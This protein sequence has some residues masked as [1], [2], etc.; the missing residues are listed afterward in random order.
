MKMI[1]IPAGRFEM[2]ENWI[3]DWVAYHTQ[4]E[5]AV[6]A[7]IRPDE[8]SGGELDET[9]RHDVNISQ[10]F[11]IASYEVTNLQYEKFDPAHR[12][13]RT[14]RNPGDNDAV[15]NISWLDATA[16]CKW[17]SD[18]E[19]LPYRLPTEAEWEYA[20]R[21][22]TNSL[23]NTGDSLPA[24]IFE[25][26][27]RSVGQAPPNAWGL[28]DMHG[29]VEEWCNDWYGPYPGN[30]QTDP[31]GPATGRVKIL[32][33]GYSSELDVDWPYLHLS[34]P[35][36]RSA[37]RAGNIPSF[38]HEYYGFRL[39]MA[40]PPGGKSL[41]SETPLWAKDV[42]Q[43]PYDWSN[44]PDPEEPFFAEI[45]EFAHPP[46]NKDKIP[47]YAINHVPAITWCENGDMLTIWWTTVRD[48]G[49]TSAILGSRLRTGAKRYDPPS[50]FLTVPDRCL[51]GS[52]LF[53][54]GQGRIIWLQNIAPGGAWNTAPL[55]VSFST[56]NGVNWTDPSIVLPGV[57]SGQ[58]AH[59]VMTRDKKGVLWQTADHYHTDEVLTGNCGATALYRS[60]DRGLNWKKVT[61]LDWQI[62]NL[63]KEGKTG[64][65]IAG[66]HGVS[67]MLQDGSLLGFGRRASIDGNLIKSLSKDGGQSW[68]YSRSDFPSIRGGQRPS[69]LRLQEGPIL[70]VSYTGLH[71]IPGHGKLASFEEP[72]TLAKSMGGMIFTDAEG[73]EYTG[74]GLYAAISYDE[75]QTWETRKLITPGGAPQIMFGGGHHHHFLMDN[76]HAE[77]GGYSY[78]T[79]TPDG[80]IHL[81][82]SN[83]HYRLNLK[84]LE[85][86]PDF[87]K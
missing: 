54:D 11:F 87:S 62:E 43:S 63:G 42:S 12:V 71:T 29:G 84:W 2:G 31:I 52:S 79:Q 67:I 59:M 56:D 41:P 23:F 51:H 44:G 7:R 19:G 85:T 75:G 46:A 1:P 32:R 72:L 66:P 25:R 53:H 16:F 50:V 5:L 17:L 22:G 83:L 30:P 9:P 24:D 60:D 69:M 73:V 28:F 37:N 81:I 18:E 68:T 4:M 40:K 33:G 82:T 35:Y 64:G 86:A 26:S 61:R 78:I 49:R 36:L 3:G 20:C 38:S 77:T 76:T 47:F 27:T 70:F 21:A 57:R 65:A 80:V 55:T 74:Y 58:P 48:G 13:L 15:G 45:I 39:V 14:G 8:W 6:N 10:A 34:Q